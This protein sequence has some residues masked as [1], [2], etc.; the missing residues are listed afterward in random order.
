MSR[1]ITFHRRFATAIIALIIA[2]ATCTQPCMA[3]DFVVMIDAGHGGKDSG[4]LGPKCKEKDINLAVALKLGK[5]LS[6]RYKD[7]K[8]VYTRTTDVFVTIKGRMDKAKPI[9]SYRSIA[10]R[11]PL[12]IPGAHPCPAPPSTFSATAMPTTT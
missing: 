7:I 11:P 6:N 8:V 10:I 1:R 12:K 5:E 2:A 3:K 4:A 9:C